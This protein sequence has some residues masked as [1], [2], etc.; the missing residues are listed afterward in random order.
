MEIKRKEE[1]GEAI[2]NHARCYRLQL[3][4]YKVDKKGI[5]FSVITRLF[6]REI[7]T[8]MKFTIM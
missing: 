1:D 4:E 3:N 7:A 8:K 5:F 2:K 6:R